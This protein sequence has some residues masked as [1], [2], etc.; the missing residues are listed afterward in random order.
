MT[1]R[2]ATNFPLVRITDSTGAVVYCA[3]HNWLGGVATGSTLVSAKFDIP[4]TIH[5]GAATLVVVA[6]GIASAR[7]EP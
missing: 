6:N 4:A 3:T 2:A 5:T 7:E 1:I